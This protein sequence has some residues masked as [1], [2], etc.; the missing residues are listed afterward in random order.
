MIT[1]K[2]YPGIDR[3]IKKQK[4]RK[5]NTPEYNFHCQV[6]D[7][8][9]KILDPRLTCWS[10]VENSNHTGGVLGAFKQ[11]KDKRK[12]VKAGYP[13]VVIFYTTTTGRGASLHIELKAGKN[14]LTKEQVAFHK[15]LIDSG[16]NVET[17]RTIDD[18]IM[19]LHVYQVPTL[20][21]E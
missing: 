6:A 15:K 11:S 19:A 12:G 1:F 17:A 3:A 14:G 2:S 18:I 5:R 13:D 7:T 8:L 10:S 21:R 20:V 4:K 16:S 9:D